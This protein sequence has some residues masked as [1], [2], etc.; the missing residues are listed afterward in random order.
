MYF[1]VFGERVSG[2][3]YREM[4]NA[5]KNRR[6]LI[7]AGLT[8]RREL[9]K[10]GLL[11]A[12][13]MLV[14]K[15]GLSSRAYAQTVNGGTNQNCLPNNQPAS[16]PTR[17][18]IEPL[19]IMPVAQTVP[20]LSPTPTL[21]PNTGAGEVRAACHQA[22]QLDGSRFPVV[23]SALYR[24]T[25]QVIQAVQSPDLPPQAIW[26]FSDGVHSTSPGPTY[27]AQYGKP[28]L[29][30]NI[31]AL[32]PA[33][34]NGGFGIP[35]VTTHLHN[36]HNPSESDG[37]PCD[38]YS[39]GHF[40][41][42]YYPNVLAG[43]N[44]DHQPEGDINESLSTL[45]YHDHRVDFTSQNTYKGLVGFYCLFN[46]FDTGSD[47]TGFRLPDFPQHDIPLVFADKVY[48][49]TTGLLAFD[50]FNLDGIL[51]DK[52]LVNGK[53][54]PFLEV[55]PRRYRFRLLDTGPSRF[56]EFFLTDLNNLST[57][58]PFFVIANDGNLLPNPVQA[59]SV[60]IGVAERVDIIIDFS[61]FAGKTIYLENRL[62]Q[63]NG[64]GPV[65]NFGPNGT[66]RECT[67]VLG[68]TINQILSP[69]Q[70]NLLLQF[71]V[72]GSAVRDDSVDPATNPSF[73]Q[74]PSTAVEPRVVRTFKFDRLNGQWS[75]NGQ[76]MDCN[77]FRFTV[78]Q[79][80]SE[81]WLLT[82]LTGDWT[83]PVHIHLEEHQIL[84]RNRDRRIPAV[85]RSRKDV[86]QLRPNE[87][88]QLFFRFRDWLGKYPIHC[89]NVVHEDHAMMALWH[90]QPEGDE[91]LVP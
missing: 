57:V 42:Q 91:V 2:A 46:Q 35:S 20:F 56:Y 43:F 30:R 4:L 54:Q 84:S 25:Q 5:A 17:P 73:Y 78:Q 49:P 81:Q 33:S 18:F 37:N 52:F 63:L 13:G 68:T 40:C 24:F 86:T 53:I 80:S 79:N 22:P 32:P 64:Q 88:V 27:R 36:A 61:K 6:E 23:P 71:R 47:D 77:Q 82:N 85:E 72:S 58:N 59:Q 44:S 67:Q 38:F 14:A 41:D 9:F 50:L 87:R 62:N 75:I 34:Q 90:V 29:T 3:R 1:N 8:S 15:S 31:N 26:G 51:G 89:H 70:G 65:D 10:M 21:C 39:P 60:R 19:P 12:G 28:Q 11:T 66:S 48:D 16:P 45:W 76:F 83:H 74:L 55:E 7:A 69:G